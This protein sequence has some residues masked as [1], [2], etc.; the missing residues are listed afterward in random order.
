MADR[1][2]AGGSEVEDLLPRRDVDVVEP[3]Q[4]ASGQL[5]PERVPH[6]VLRL[7]ALRA[8]DGD[9]L[10]AVHGVSGDEVLGDEEVLLA[11]RDEDARVTMRLKDD[12]GAA[13]GTSPASSTP[14]PPSSSSTAAAS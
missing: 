3:A 8:L 5:A 12:V 6:P 2:P 13:L 4:D 9:A 10:L 14:T 1:G 7:L 11:L